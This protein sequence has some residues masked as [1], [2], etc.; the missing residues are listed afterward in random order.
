MMY[1]EIYKDKAGE[2]RFRTVTRTGAVVCASEGYKRKDYALR[3]IERI[4]AYAASAEIVD[5]S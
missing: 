4:K 2:F 3:S 5:N 1:F